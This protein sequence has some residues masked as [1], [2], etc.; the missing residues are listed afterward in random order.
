MT[1]RLRVLLLFGGRSAEHDVSCVT[2]VAV[3]R[4]LDPEKYEIVPIAITT[5]GEWLLAGEASAALAKG[6]TALPDA[7]L[8]EGEPVSPPTGPAHQDIVSRADRSGERSGLTPDVV[9]PL[10]HGPYGED[11]T[12]QG[13]LELAGLPYVGA[14]VLGSAVAMDKIMMKR[15]FAA[16]GLRQAR[17]LSL[18][19]GHDRDAFASRVEGELGLP[20]FVKPANMGSSVGVTKAHDRAE[21]GAA[22]VLAFHYDEWCVAEEAIVGREIE[23]AVLGDDPP[24][25]SLPGEVVPADEFY[26][27]ADKYEGDEAQLIVPAPLLG[28][29]VADAQAIAV[30]AFEACR[31]EAMA[32]VDLF[33]EDGP[34]G[35]GFLVNEINT[36][37]GF[38]PIS[39]YPK[40]WEA[41]GIPYPELLDRLIDLALA[42]HA[43]R[44]R[45]AGRQR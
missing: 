41:S 16:A 33:L 18:R 6:E 38:T 30:R 34:G 43:R 19:D 39:M 42:R 5:A 40:L 25:A 3:A 4:A 44:A 20:A 37:P 2:A 1:R 27:Y 17:T 7:F 8:V 32:R 14:G 21:L 28:S 31:C 13:L 11:G 22:I 9:I 45:R 26:S 23:V 10:L 29:L 15:A 35:R 24:V 12:V 36:I